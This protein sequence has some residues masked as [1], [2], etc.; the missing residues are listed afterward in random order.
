MTKPFLH[1]ALWTL[2]GLLVI[3]GLTGCTAPPTATATLPPPSVTPSPTQLPTNTPPATLTPTVAPPTPTP[4]LTPPPATNTPRPTQT[5]VPTKT[6]APLPPTAPPSAP[7]VD[8]VA[9][10]GQETCINKSISVSF[11][12]EAGQ[13]DRQMYYWDRNWSLYLTFARPNIKLQTVKALCDA[14]NQCRGFTADFCVYVDGN[15]PS[16]GTYESVLN[17]VIFSALPNGSGRKVLAEVN[18]RFSWQIK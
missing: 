4:T 6:P 17:L 9:P 11:P 18:P 5:P 2:T 10:R 7:G 15:A 3:A 8:V 13:G 14:Q 12:W 16:G 1:R